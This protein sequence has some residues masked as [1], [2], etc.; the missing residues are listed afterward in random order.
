MPLFR[1]S[2]GGALGNP[3]GLPRVETWPVQERWA[4]P[5]VGL[6]QRV[7]ELAPDLMLGVGFLAAHILKGA[8]PD[9]PLVFLTVGCRQAKAYVHGG[10]RDVVALERLLRRGG[11]WPFVDG[12][13]PEAVR[14]ADFVITHSE[15][16][17]EQFRAFYDRWRG[18][19]H[20]EVV[21]FAEWIVDDARTYADFRRPFDDREIDVLFV[22]NDW[23]RWEKNWPL[24]RKLVRRLQGLSVHVA[25]AGADPLRGA[26]L[27]GLVTD[28]ARLFALLGNAKTV[29]SP[30]RSDPAP[31][32]LFEGGAMGCNLVASK[33][34]GN[35]QICHPELLADPPRA[36]VYVDRVRRSMTRE[37]PDR[38]DRFL[39]RQSYAELVEI[40]QAF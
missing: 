26:V 10:V 25:G 4:K 29:V 23:R 37:F 17:L 32:I 2:F 11:P 15:Q 34:A 39:D 12:G 31:G 19:I 28:R 27:E 7:A 40:V 16:T 6:A 8:A 24:V 20:P 30:S 33:N 21:S 38:L 35:W 36:A 18:K 14:R 22:A 13:E 9:R 1:D 3:Q 5:D